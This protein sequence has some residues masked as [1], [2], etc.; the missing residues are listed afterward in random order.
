MELSEL[1]FK[2]NTDQLKEAVVLLQQVESATSK[3][4]KVQA[5]Q[6][7]AAAKA[8]AAETKLAK[9]NEVTTE[10][11]AK[12][13]KGTEAVAD[14]N[15]K[16][17]K[18]ADTATEAMKKLKKGSKEV[19]DEV[20]PLT[21][22]I[23]NLKNKYIDLSRGFTNGESSVLKQA[24]NYG[25]VGDALLPVIKQLEDIR[26]LSAAPLD[27]NLG[28]IRSIQK[29]FDSMTNRT[30]FLSEGISLTTKQLGEYSRI[31]FE[32]EGQ[33]KGM[34]LDPKEGKGLELYNQ[35]LL[36]IQQ[37]YIGLAGAVN[38]QRE[39]E[40]LL[41][42]ERRKVERESAKNGSGV[43]DN[44]VA[45]FKQAQL[46]KLKVEATMMDSAVAKFYTNQERLAKKVDVATSSMKEQ[47]R[48][49][50]WLANEEERM[51]SVSKTLAA[52]QDMN[53]ISSERAAKAI[54]LYERNL[55]QAGVAG[56]EAAKKIANYR[57]YSEEIQ[58]SEEARKGKFLSRALQPQIGDTVVSLAAGQNPLTVL[59]QQGDQIRG[60]IAQSGLE[61]AKLSDVMRSAF[62]STITSIKDT[63]IAMGSVLGGA[64]LSTG[65]MFSSL[66]TGPIETFK[67][68]LMVG[69]DNGLVGLPALFDA[70]S[71]ASADFG[72]S[73]LRLSAIPMIAII[74]ALA[75][76]GTAFY[77]VYQQEQEMSKQ[78]ILNGAAMG[79]TKDSAIALAQSMNQVGVS[80]HKSMEVISAMIGTGNLLKGDFDAINQAAQAMEKA[81]GPAIEETVKMFSKLREKP[82][83]ALIE[84]ARTSGL[85]TPQIL[86]EVNKLAATGNMADAIALAM[87]TGTDVVRIQAA[88]MVKELSLLGKAIKGVS[89]LWSGMMN[90]FRGGM[91]ADSASKVLEDKIKAV[92]A[93]NKNLVDLASNVNNPNK[94]QNDK[95]LRENTDKIAALKE[96]LSLLK[97]VEGIKADELASQSENARIQGLKNSLKERLDKQE[98]SAMK[99]KLTMQEYINKAL[100]E[101]VKI[102]GQAL[103]PE[104]VAKVTKVARV[105]FDKL[106]EKKGKDPT[107]SKYQSELKA[108]RDASNSVLNKEDDLLAG[109]TEF[110]AHIN[111]LR[112]KAKKEDRISAEE[113]KERLNAYLNQQPFMIAAIKEEEKAK[114][115]LAKAQ[116]KMNSLI[117]RADFL[118]AEYYDTLKLLN[119]LEGKAGIDP[120]QLKQAKE[121]LE[122]TTPSAKAFAAVMADYAKTIDDVSASSTALKNE[123]TIDF[124]SPDDKS[125]L[126]A[127]EELIK[128][129]SKAEAEYRKQLQQ[130][131]SSIDDSRLQAANDAALEALNAKKKLNQEVHDREAYL[132]SESYKSNKEYA[133]S[134]IKL[135]NDTTKLLTDEFMDFAMFGKT[136]FEGLAVSF[137]KMINSMINNLLR[138]H[139]QQKI[140]D[141]IKEGLSGSLDVLGLSSSRGVGSMAN[142]FGGITSA[143]SLFDGAKSW[144]NDF[145]G[146]VAKS[147]TSLGSQ[148]Y[149]LGL[150]K[151][152]LALGAGTTGA[153]SVA[154]GGT[155]LAAM[156]GG[157]G[158][159]AGAGG[160]TGLTLG[161]STS[162]GL[163]GAATG[164]AASTSA[165]ST[166]SSY[167]KVAGEALGYLNTA[168]L[169]SEGKW[170]A[171]IGS[172]IGA[173]FGGPIGS[174]IGSAVGGWVDKA[175]GGGSEYTT[176]QGISGKFSK[177]GFSGR[178][179]QDWQNDGSSGFFGIGG[180]GRSSGTNY[181]QMDSSLQDKLS[182]AFT[183]IQIQTAGFAGALGIDASK[184]VNYSQDIKLAL[185]TDAS[186]NK[187]AIENTFKD[188]ANNIA[189]VVLDPKYIKD[190]ESAS[191][192]LSRLANS[193][194]SVN[195]VF[196]VLGDT[197]LSLSQSSADSADKLI[198]LMGGQQAYASSMDTYYKSFYTAEERQAKA[199][200]QLEAEFVKLGQALPI[201]IEGYRNLVNAQDITTESGRNTYAALIA[202]SSSFYELSTTASAFETSMIE[203]AK[204]VKSL[205][206]SVTAERANV[207][208]SVNS[209][210]P[211]SVMTYADIASG[212]DAARV[213]SPE[214][215]AVTQALAALNTSN[216]ALT[217][218]NNLATT[219]ANASNA[220]NAAR[221]TMTSALS[222]KNSAES[223]LSN[224]PSQIWEHYVYNTFW[225]DRGGD[226]LVANPDYANA[227]AAV[228]TANQNY[229]AA[230]QQFNTVS[231]S[232]TGSTAA[233][234]PSAQAALVAATAARNAAE[235]I[236][237]ERQTEYN[238]AVKKFAVD[239][240]L[241]VKSLSNL[242]EETLRYYEAQKA[243]SNLMITSATNLRNA[244]NSARNSQLNTSDSLQQQSTVFN[245][246]YISALSSTNEVQAGFA[247]KMTAIIPALST[248]LA[249]T[250]S[251]RADWV[252]ATSDLFSKSES[253]AN[254]L[255]ASA[256]VDF[257][258][259]SLALLNQIDDSLSYIGD[260]TEIITNAIKSGAGLTAA[261][262]RQVVQ[263][264]GGTPAFASGGIHSGGLRLVG[265]NGPELELTGPSRIFNAAETRGILGGNF[266][267]SSSSSNTAR[268]EALVERQ[269]EQLEGMR[270][271][272]R[273]IATSSGKT[274]QILQRVTPDGTSLQTA[275]AA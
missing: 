12:L 30:K 204:V 203:I 44:P 65:K 214:L 110:Y 50:K 28:A 95:S 201:T 194:V 49:T 147:A 241:S 145:G 13:V 87:K 127:R 75:M 233:L 230:T 39:A 141:M 20:D 149:D 77:Q 216:D 264:L 11:N 257:Q 160:V 272:L 42:E 157:T 169:A 143:S 123:Y 79:L 148:F 247:D 266:S 239:S 135:G 8:A 31:A 255:E 38:T 159:T 96:Q 91:Y 261:G 120:E 111:F 253:I 263:A 186:A 99:K 189:K 183:A 2:V 219:T 21:K 128:S 126:K 118:G 267:N 102:R 68:A 270:Y 238:D 74:G 167:A 98:D 234:N 109:T 35:R 195:K 10:S 113:E 122:A 170:G 105:T 161:S 275:V 212:I 76:A 66:V 47:Q 269:A 213:T 63:A 188:I 173:Y 90:S 17:A 211:R 86:E 237:I 48:A 165:F 154:T 61:G 14:A 93:S 121:A 22:L 144:L 152:G 67:I 229:A 36:E 153:M 168:I 59:L 174:V 78:T 51:I 15:T 208:N 223:T 231:N 202:L 190:G 268:L 46:E 81:G 242:R 45:Q 55:R 53:V 198:T 265:E 43:M 191:D 88:E 156:G 23:D 193:L 184:I 166:I 200:Q 176:S 256:P 62:T 41:N 260:A 100:A 232:S 243:L 224:T 248:A 274:A 178:N 228:T 205:M 3:L 259:A 69:K 7:S 106:H 199:K 185:G 240:A 273:A 254:T 29:E 139:A 26:T 187:A 83:E 37:K 246:A 73:L 164:T 112:N 89:E 196:S 172:G 19:E 155:Q 245:S 226:R 101:E 207:A 4:G 24:R 175:F 85:V 140:S 84:L 138:F 177:T 5:E 6:A 215:T 244:V 58:I 32:I 82:V 158:L 60:L 179:Y 249:D 115:D 258:A 171:A 103:E 117:G 92:E 104:E 97:K 146:S 64:I 222:Q 206:D 56:D 182:N 262:L 54:A 131:K 80:T 116:E 134:I 137:D 235:K 150:E 197:M 16:L 33:I 151:I 181:S 119:S 209:V 40:R 252:L 236:L 133:D 72:K 210:N 1:S 163:Q 225:G 18:G 250:A 108:A 125:K 124:L 34:K 70:A 114:G 57:K 251:T 107:E 136:S 94:L 227:Q 25:A 192:T 52:T 271:E 221:D 132:L 9:G 220:L 217:V 162:L 71:H 180:S 142:A 130:N 27:P 218:A 129:N